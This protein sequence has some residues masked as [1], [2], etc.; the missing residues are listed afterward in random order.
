MTEPRPA[1]YQKRKPL[2]QPGDKP[3]TTPKSRMGL[4]RVLVQANI[5]R[6]A[7]QRDM[8]ESA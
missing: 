7:L 2:S 1:K 8:T 4:A 6:W 5:P 3:T